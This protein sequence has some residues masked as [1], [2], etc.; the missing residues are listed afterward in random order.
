MD[1]VSSA[2]REKIGAID[3]IAVIHDVERFLHPTEKLSLKL[4][5][6]NFFRNKIAELVKLGDR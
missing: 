6:E 1:W 3:W 4:W 2:L 5:S